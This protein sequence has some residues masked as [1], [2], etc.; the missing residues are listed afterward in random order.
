MHCGAGWADGMLEGI[1][2][3]IAVTLD[4]GANVSRAHRDEPV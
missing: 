2:E 3:G 1:A 4:D